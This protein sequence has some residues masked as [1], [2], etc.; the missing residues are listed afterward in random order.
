MNSFTFIQLLGKGSFGEVYLVKK[1]SNDKHFAM[2]ILSKHQLL[3]NN[4]VKYATYIR[5]NDL[6]NLL[7]RTERN[8]MS[9]TR[10]PFI[11]GLNYAFQTQTK[12]I[13]VM[14]YCSG[15]DLGRLLTK[16]KR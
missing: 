3:K 8:V 2:K 4:L 7:F 1:K 14:D 12:L 13:L 9:Y 15:G 16:K 6:I 5:V 10:H 11:V